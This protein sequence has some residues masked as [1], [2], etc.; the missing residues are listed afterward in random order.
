VLPAVTLA[1][2]ILPNF[3][4][5]TRASVLDTINE[6]FVVT[7]RAKGLSRARVLFFHVLPN[8]LNPIM[9][10]LGLQ[11]GRLMGGSIITETIF[12]WPG[13]GRLMIGSIFQRD[14]PVVI[15]AVF[16]VSLIIIFANLLVDVLLSLN[17]PRIRLG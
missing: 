13:I 3:V 11:I 6:Q 7:A 2:F 8:A 17:D 4:L 9:S 10:F 5:I 15:S 1:T 16:I 12:A 14:V